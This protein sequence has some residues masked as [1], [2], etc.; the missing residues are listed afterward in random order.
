M[1]RLFG[2]SEASL[3]LYSLLCSLAGVA[4]ALVLGRFLF[5]TRH[6]LIAASLLVIMPLDVFYA[7]R[8]FADE[9]VGFWSILAYYLF[10]SGD[11]ADN[12][13]R[14]M[15]GGVSAG[16]AYLTKETS[17]FIYVPLVLYLWPGSWR[18]LGRLGVFTAGMCLILLAES[19]FWLANTGDPLF[20]LHTVVASR[21]DFVPDAPASQEHTLPVLPGP[22]PDEMFRSAN[23]VVDAV[24]M[25]LTNEECGFLYYLVWP[26][27]IYFWWNRDK[28]TRELRVWIVPLALLLLF[29][30]LHFPRYTLNRDP[31][32]YTVLSIPALLILVHWLLQQRSWQRWLVIAGL[33]ATWLLCICVGYL[34][35]QMTVERQVVLVHRE[36]PAERLWVSN[37]LAADVTI[38]S[39][40]DRAG[41]LG[42]H[43]LEGAH[44]SGPG[45]S[46]PMRAMRPSIPV[47]YE[48][49][50]IR[51]GLVVFEEGASLRPPADWQLVRR[52]APDTPP[53]ARFMQRCLYACG[54]AKNICG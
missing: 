40:F 24:L 22:K 23:T 46:G 45:L 18:R 38:L 12:R 9:A 29:F 51:G 53:L 2:C 14:L 34:S 48:T 20:R 25:F 30:P 49:T 10:L 31:R 35:S 41:L 7:T 26:L 47:A 28:S 32:Y 43:W 52:I 37:R 42:V 17:L 21:H 11:V 5:D 54:G 4:M 39:G 33:C 36:Y 15:G 16:V 8:A 27:I 1:I 50:E 19:G 13:L 44:L 6:G 3:T